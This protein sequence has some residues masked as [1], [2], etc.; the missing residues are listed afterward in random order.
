MFKM[1]F[2]EA[3]Y[4]SELRSGVAGHFSYRRVAWEMYRAVERQHPSLAKLFRIE[5]VNEPVDLLKR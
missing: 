2:A 5:N 4:I 3:L 1:D